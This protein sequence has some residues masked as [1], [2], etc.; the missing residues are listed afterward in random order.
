MDKELMGKDGKERLFYWGKFV[1]IFLTA[2]LAVQIL[3]ALKDLNKPEPAYNVV[4]VVGEGEVIS[5]PDVATFSFAVSMDAKTV[6]EAQSQVTEKM[7]II[8]ASLK[9]LG[10]EDRDV[11]TSNYS[12]WPKYSYSQEIC[13]PTYCPP[14]RQVQDG[15][16]ANHN[17][18]LK[19]RKVDEIGRVLAVVGDNGA[20]NISGISFVIDDPDQL[21]EEARAK[22]IEDAKSKAKTLANNLN[23]RL[24]RVI[25]FSEYANGRPQ[26]YFETYAL[27]EDT[28]KASSA[29]T[30]PAGE[31]TTNVS[32]NVTYEIR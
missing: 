5:I 26:P 9:N 13:S 22:A 4:S 10:V 17:I 11:K 14:S 19:V 18:T 30:L 8:L 21:M 6:S 28:M 15:Y 29:P 3:G 27:G 25:S 1:L 12:I 20:T 32:V 24:V 31:N 2:F 7:D 16:T 23:V